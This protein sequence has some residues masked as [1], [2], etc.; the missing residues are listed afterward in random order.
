MD[1]WFNSMVIERL[2]DEVE[3]NLDAS[4]GRTYDIENYIIG[5]ST[6]VIILGVVV[7]LVF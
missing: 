1:R 2:Q 3:G 4:W 6:V 7:W 5:L